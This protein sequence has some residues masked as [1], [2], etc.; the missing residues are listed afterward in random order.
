M[1]IWRP[2]EMGRA[3]ALV[4]PSKLS[5]VRLPYRLGPVLRKH[6][7]AKVIREHPEHLDEDLWDRS[8]DQGGAVVD[9]DGPRFLVDAHDLVQ[10]TDLPVAL[11]RT[12]IL[13]DSYDEDAYSAAHAAWEREEAEL[14]AAWD[15]AQ[16]TR[17]ANWEEAEAEFVRTLAAWKAAD[18]G[19][20]PKAAAWEAAKAAAK[21]RRAFVKEYGDDRL[22]SFRRSKPPPMEPKPRR[23]HGAKRPSLEPRPAFQEITFGGMR[24]SNPNPE[25]SR[26]WFPRPGFYHYVLSEEPR[27]GG[28]TYWLFRE[29]V[30]STVEELT[31][32]EVRALLLEKENKAKARIAR[33]MALM[34]QV[35]QLSDSGRREAIPDDVRMFVWQRDRG[36]CVVCGTRKDLEFDHLIPLSMG[37]S[38]TARNLQLLCAGCNRS[39]GG[40]L[41]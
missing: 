29:A 31:P 40:N 14:D 1:A 19:W 39:K 13:E 23:L 8:S 20:R 41:A 17:L 25:P 26:Y 2:G 22:W 37:G 16:R 12:L 27:V 4:S 7:A 30:F 32:E 28:R 35:D 18:A 15:E 3:L 5:A 24:H 34:E 21:A 6:A 36:Q 33:A 10:Q 38:N 9:T 11:H